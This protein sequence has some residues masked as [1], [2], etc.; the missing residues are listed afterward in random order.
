[1]HREGNS[2]IITGNYSASI[3]SV[4][5]DA[6]GCSYENP[7]LLTG[8]V[9]VPTH[10]FQVSRA[11][12][13]VLHTARVYRPKNL[14]KWVKMNFFLILWRGCICTVAPP[15]SATELCDVCDF[16]LQS[17]A[18]LDLR[19]KKNRHFWFFSLALCIIFGSNFLPNWAH[20]Y[21]IEREQDCECC[22]N[23]YN[24][25]IYSVWG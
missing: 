20:L 24:L 13:V 25:W 15:G 11:L 16:R 10:L 18:K 22:V 14:Q 19:R 1:M 4:I 17:Q 23:V 21:N 5:E 6:E 2:N 3:W 9:G 7:C 12:S 8:F